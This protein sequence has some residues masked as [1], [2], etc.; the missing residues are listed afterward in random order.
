[1]G[2]AGMYQKL[3]AVVGLV[4][5]TGILSQ[6]AIA[7]KSNVPSS[8]LKYNGTQTTYATD[9]YLVAGEFWE[10]IKPM[11]TSTPN[12][13]EDPLRSGGA[14]HFLTFGPDGGNWLEPGSHWPGGYDLVST[15]RDGKR[16]TF[17]A[18]EGSGWGPNALQPGG[19]PDDRFAFAYYTPTVAGAGDPTRNY[20][21]PAR[22]TDA[23]RTH[24]IY[25]AGWPTNIG[26]DFKI[27]G[28]QYTINEQNMNDFVAVEITMTNTGE[29]DID[30]DGTVEISGH[31]IDA[32]ASAIWV[33]P[34]ISVRI[35]Q[36][37]GR[38]NRFGAG[39]TIGYAGAID[40]DTGEPYDIF[41]FFPNVPEGRYAAGATPGP[42]TRRIGVNDGAILEGYTDVWH[43]HRYT[44]VKQGSIVD[45]DLGVIPSAPDKM[46]LFGTHPIGTGA[47]RGWYSSVQ[48]ENALFGFNESEQAF[49]SATATWYQDYGKNST[50]NAS[51]NLAP[52]SNFFSGGTPD[53]VTSFVVGA[54]A[55]RPNGDIKYASIDLGNAAGARGN[56]SPVWEDALLGT[57]GNFYST[58]GHTKIHTFGQD[59]SAGNGPYSLAV[60][61]SITMVLTEFA[62]FRFEGLADAS[63]AADWAMA[64]GWDVSADLPAPPAP[65]NRV[66]STTSG[67]TLLRWTDVSAE[68]A[69]AGTQVDGY[70]IY[71]AAQF[72]RTNWLDKG[73]RFVDNY[74]RLNT[75]DGD[76]APYLDPVNPYFDAQSE[77]TGDIQGSYQPSEWGPYTLIANIPAGDLSQYADASAGYD[78]AYEDIN[79]ITGFTYWYYVAAYRSG[80]FTGP[81]GPVSHLESS[82]FTRNGRND[83]AAAD[84]VLGLGSPW[85]GTYGYAI[86]N[87]DYPAAGTQE[88]KN[89]GSP[90]TVTPPVAPDADVADAITV[91]PNPYI[92]T[93]LND[94]RS[95]S[96][97]H[98]INFLNLPRQYVLT[99]M[100]VSG[101]IVFQASETDA[102]NGQFSWN[103]Q[104]KDGVEVA[105]GLYIYHVEFTFAR[106]PVFNAR[107]QGSRSVTGHFAILR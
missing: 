83:P 88:Y 34:T 102:V 25:E 70:K 47:Q 97:S 95:I 67:T 81:Q 14:Q 20:T 31:E 22:F 107:S 66:E 12:G 11:N 9:G 2:N 72:E 13:V 52:N 46:N 24:M 37:A 3:T 80:S 38:S 33:E 104:S 105:S 39:R 32:I 6:P 106:D 76:I 23:T 86:R 58:I 10:T 77:F 44:A 99:I 17:P 50:D 57:A 90:F 48:W 75:V 73:F 16:T 98:N 19:A 91:S 71:R 60:G 7:Q 41:Y 51:I 78:Y 29:V 79:S 92:V 15:W 63:K 8:L 26:V 49:R 4:L 30:G 85:G 61:E 54:P 100:D 93:G 82:N 1:M 53:D 43:G 69:S 55:A 59:P 42:G 74:Q 36:T 84:G 18:F 89:I 35:T 94:V 96:T 65:D 40:P 21:R 87:A 68:A 28:H 62:G 27:R 101:Q 56:D 64:R 5:V 103:M 45:G